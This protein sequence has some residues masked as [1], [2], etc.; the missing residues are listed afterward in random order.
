M[1]KKRKEKENSFL[2]RKVYKLNDES[3]EMQDKGK[4]G[5]RTV[6]YFKDR[7]HMTVF[8]PGYN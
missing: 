4:S 1:K 8:F 6:Y 5:K 2:I 3:V 7:Q